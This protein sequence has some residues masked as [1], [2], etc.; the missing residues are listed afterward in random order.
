MEKYD[1]SFYNY[2]R[3]YCYK[4][5]AEAEAWLKQIVIDESYEPAGE[6]PAMEK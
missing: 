5:V 2:A 1:N 6:Q 4:F 3:G